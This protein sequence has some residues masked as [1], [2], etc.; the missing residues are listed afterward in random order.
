MATFE[1]IVKIIDNNMVVEEKFE[2]V[3]N[4][5]KGSNIL[6]DSLSNVGKYL[7]S[8][9]KLDN[10][11]FDNYHINYSE[12]NINKIISNN[13]SIICKFQ[14]LWYS[15]SD[16]ERNIPAFLT[17]SID[18]KLEKYWGVNNFA[19]VKDGEYKSLIYSDCFDSYLSFIDYLQLY[20]ISIEHNNHFK[21]M[22]E[23]PLSSPNI[24]YT[25]REIINEYLELDRLDLE[26]S[27]F[28]FYS[29]NIEV[30]KN[31]SVKKLILERNK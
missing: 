2:L 26:D 7:S 13:E 25:L 28:N 14:Y 16:I 30:V 4:P 12:K 11:C 6:N 17:G 9:N 20:D 10:K 19:Y 27:R 3:R 21:E 5:N 22:L 1:D 31:E 29:N 23:V 18:Y 15:K 8:Y 24:L